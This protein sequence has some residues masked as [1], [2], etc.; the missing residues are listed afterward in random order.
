MKQYDTWR[1]RAAE[2]VAAMKM[3]DA[4][5]WHGMFKGQKGEKGGIS[6]IM[7]G[8]RV[9]NLADAQQYYGLSDNIN[10][11]KAVYDQVSRYRRN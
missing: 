7:G 2:A 10:R 6:Y 3:E 11:Y 9:F 4:T 1:H 8:S 5:Y